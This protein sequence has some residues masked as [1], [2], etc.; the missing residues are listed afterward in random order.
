[1]SNETNT[2]DALTAELAAVKAELEQ[3]KRQLARYE[4]AFNT[5]PDLISVLDRNYVY[6]MANQAY[7]QIHGGE[8][9]TVIGLTSTDIVGPEIFE[10]MVKP[11]LDRCFTGETIAYEA[12]GD[13]WGG[14]Y[15]VK[16]QMFPYREVDGSISGAIVYAQDMTRLKLAEQDVL[17]F[18]NMADYA[19]DGFAISRDGTFIYANPAFKKMTGYEDELIGKH[20]KILYDLNEVDLRSIIKQIDEA[21][22][23]QGILPYTR[24]DGSIFYGQLSVFVLSDEETQD[25]ILRF[26]TVRDITDQLDAEAEQERLQQEIITTQQRMIKE[27]STPI[28]PLMD[29][30]IIMPLVGTID[31]MRAQDLMRTMLKGI[32]QHR[33][34]IVILDITGVSLIDTGIAAYLDR[35]IHAARLKGAHTILT[36]ISDAVAETVIELGID[37]SHVETLRDLQTGLAVAL[38]RMDI[39]WI[40]TL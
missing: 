6:Q 10:Q 34:K 3:T 33:A 24:K 22:Y 27:L 16:M 20:V 14:R 36:G 9:G 19:I 28:I 23:W 29:G 15:Y 7:Q 13:V 25:G 2:I 1:M 39:Q 21:G 40:S 30:I 32:S 8:S 5:L 38:Q 37:W 11:A 4:Q 26:A 12:W 17:K 18:K 31:A 35:T